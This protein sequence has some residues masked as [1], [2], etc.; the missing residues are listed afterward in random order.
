MEEIW[1]DVKGF[2]GYYQISNLGNLKSLDRYQKGKGGT[3]YF[4]KGRIMKHCLDGKGYHY[5]Y[6]SK[7]NVR[8]TGK[9]HRL[10]AK[11]FIPNPENK[12]QV[13]HLR[14]KDNND[15]DSIEWATPKENVVHAWKNNLCESKKGINSNANK[16]SEKQVYEI[17]LLKGIK[18]SREVG[19]Q[20]NVSKTSILNIW[21]NKL[22]NHL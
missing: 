13:N 6:L 16:L 20:Y 19:L 7:D 18:T 8:T 5:C 14:G 22:W 17:K 10:V 1:K 12:S 21:N 4:V 9:I 15:V 2:K 11:A 3:M